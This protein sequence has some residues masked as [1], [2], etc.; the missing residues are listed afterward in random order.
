[1]Q[2]QP[3]LFI[4]RMPYKRLCLRPLSAIRGLLVSLRESNSLSQ[5]QSALGPQ[6]LG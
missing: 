2:F 6:N 3:M 5:N 4:A 1:M